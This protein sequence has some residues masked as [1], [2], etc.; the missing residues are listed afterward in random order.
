MGREIFPDHCAIAVTDPRISCPGLIGVERQAA[1]SMRPKRRQ[2]FTAGR[3]AVRRAMAELDL[4][5]RAIPMGPDRAPVWPNNLRGSLTHCASACLAVLTKADLLLGVD[6]EPNEPLTDDVTDLVCSAAEQGWLQSSPETTR[7]NL[8]RL[9]FC[10]KEAAFKAQYHLSKR[11]FDFTTLRIESEMAGHRFTATFTAPI[12]PF[13]L[14][15]QIKGQFRI[16]DELILAGVTI[17]ASV[18]K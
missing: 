10:A 17:E 8:S 12:A 3:I 14:G 4:P 15:Y 6:V 1:T 13:P 5:A 18:L 2:E 11:V 9:I 16:S 7:G